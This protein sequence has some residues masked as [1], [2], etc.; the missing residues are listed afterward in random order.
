MSALQVTNSQA[1]IDG[2]DLLA[3]DHGLNSTVR[4]IDE[5]RE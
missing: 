4:T 2:I 3:L 5:Q 1:I